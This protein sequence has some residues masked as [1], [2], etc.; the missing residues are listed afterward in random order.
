MKWFQH[1]SNFSAQD[2]MAR[3]IISEFKMEGF[4]R[5]NV[6]IE[7]IVSCVA[8]ETSIPGVE[9]Y[10]KD[11]CLFLHCQP[12]VFKRFLDHL[13]DIPGMLVKRNGKSVYIQIDKISEWLTNRS[14]S[15]NKR[16]S[17]GS[18]RREDIRSNKNR[19]DDALSTLNSEAVNNLFN[20]IDKWK[21]ESKSLNRIPTAIQKYTAKHG[22]HETLL[23]RVETIIKK[24]FFNGSNKQRECG[25]GLI[26]NLNAAYKKGAADFLSYQRNRKSREGFT[27]PNEYS[28]GPATEMRQ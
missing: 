26:K 14:I 6:I 8:D 18:P 25:E 15:S 24:Q 9:H 16:G 2:P 12:K 1:Q 13:E 10:E 28:G 3:K 17:I 4:G 23:T 27:H 20:N 5:L 19:E 21:N 22:P 11:W 7:Q